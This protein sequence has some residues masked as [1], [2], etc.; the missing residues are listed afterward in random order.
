MLKARI[1]NVGE[2]KAVLNAIGD[3][4]DD[5]MFIVNDD[6]ITFR[7]MDSS[8]VALL[9]VT[10]P[11]SSFE[12]LDTKTSF[13]GLRVDDFKTVM[14]TASNEDVVELQI[15]NQGLLNVSIK[16]PLSMEYNI[17]L[18]E[19][20][21]V[22][23]P[24]PKTE[25]K[26]KLSMEPET[27]ARILSNIEKISDHVTIDCNLSRV[28]FSGKGDVGDAKINLDKGNPELKQI[29]SDED[30]IAVYSLEYMAKIIRDIGKASKLVKME[31]ANKNPIHINF[32]MPSMA[33]VEYY[34]APRVDA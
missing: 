11:K 1:K 31:Y 21:E 20:K 4:V 15:E 6:G 27:L 16:G 33:R 18:L 13:F 9:D 3:I 32:E 7:G 19:K 34:L 17:R 22:N 12:E 25:Y 2:W 28:E 24:I 8:H 23:T 30:S 5:A 26:A 14:N 29:L 10:F